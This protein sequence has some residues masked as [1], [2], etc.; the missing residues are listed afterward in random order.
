MKTRPVLMGIGG[1][2][3]FLL[4]GG[5]AGGALLALLI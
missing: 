1:A 3:V 4:A 2:A 5:D